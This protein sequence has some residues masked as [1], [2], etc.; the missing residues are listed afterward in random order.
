MRTG[1]VTNVWTKI[2]NRM[3][4]IENHK[5][6]L[7]AR[8]IAKDSTKWQVVSIEGHLNHYVIYL[9]TD[10][11]WEKKVTL[12]RA[13]KGHNIGMYEMSCRRHSILVSLHT[14]GNIKRF[15]GDLE[16]LIG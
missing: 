7:G 8:L 3:L 16:T 12:H 1:V 14:L 15:E 6:L 5:K 4:T 11:G 13:H 10:D 9:E 2:T